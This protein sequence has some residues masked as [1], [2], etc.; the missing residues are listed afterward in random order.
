MK[1]L[2]KSKER[3]REREREGVRGRA[4]ERERCMSLDAKNDYWSREVYK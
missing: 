1:T 4:R 3:D 2:I